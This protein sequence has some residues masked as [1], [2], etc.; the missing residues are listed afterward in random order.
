MTADKSV[1]FINMIDQLVTNL[2]T[3]AGNLNLV[4]NWRQKIRTKNDR[5]K[6]N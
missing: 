2:N 5:L 4:K 1:K 3:K 6:S